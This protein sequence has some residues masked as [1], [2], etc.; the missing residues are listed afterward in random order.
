MENYL[1]S[2]ELVEMTKQLVLAEFV[3]WKHE[4]IFKW[5][6]WVLIVLFFAPW[7]AW[8]KL[9][10]KQRLLPLVLFLLFI[11]VQ[12]ITFDEIFS[13][14]PLRIYTHELIPVLPRMTALDYVVVPIMFTLAYQRFVAWNCFFWANTAVAS[15]ISFVGEPLFKC[16]GFYVPIKWKYFYGFP[17]L[18]AMGLL[19]KWLVDTI[20]A[21]PPKTKKPRP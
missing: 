17:V 19:S 1:S 14:M 6:W 2:T 21:N 20:M 18:L 15:F 11:M 8:Y 4:T 5:H 7:L 9:A 12:A 3:F 16:L 13:I 10:D